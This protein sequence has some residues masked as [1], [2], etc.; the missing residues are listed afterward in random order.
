MG[1]RYAPVPSVTIVMVTVAILAAVATTLV[2]LP[3]ILVLGRLHP[4]WRRGERSQAV[5]SV[6]IGLHTAAA[7]WC[8]A[9]V[10]TTDLVP[11]AAW[12][13]T[14]VSVLLACA[15]TA[16]TRVPDVKRLRLVSVSS[17]LFL[18]ATV[19]CLIGL[20]PEQG[21]DR[22]VPKV[23]AEVPSWKRGNARPEAP[24]VVLITLDTFR[25]DRIGA[26]GQSPTLTPEIDRLA[27]EGVLFERAL[28]AAPWTVPSIASIL[29]GLPALEHRAGM[30]SSSGMTYDRSPLS[31]GHQTLA[32]D[33]AIA[34]YRTKAVVANAFLGKSMGVAQGFEEC[35]NLLSRAFVVGIL[36]KLPLTRLISNLE[37]V[38]RWGDYRAEGI[39]NQAL[40]WLAEES[41]EPLFLWAHYNDPHMPYQADPDVFLPGNLVDGSL[42]KVPE[43]GEDGLVV[44]EYFSS[45][46]PVRSGVL[47]LE[48]EDRQRLA[49]HYDRA[50][51]YV[52]KHLG[53][54]FEA[55]RERSKQRGRPLLIVLT[56]DHGEEL[57]DHGG[58][59]HGHDYY[60]EVTGV[61]LI[62]WSLNLVSPG[63]RVE[64]V[65]G[66]V[67]IAPTV[68]EWAN[69]PLPGRD[70]GDLPEDHG[71]SLLPCFRGDTEAPNRRRYSG[72]NLYGLPAGQ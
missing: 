67:D 55:L 36:E 52:D 27:T 70:S 11:T 65:V 18:I 68:R 5:W 32:E 4:A 38:R 37:G 25:V 19:L 20:Q 43:T 39:N 48:Q 26:Y 9:D 40:R 44:G 30:P 41:P 63:R 23:A 1:V 50:I 54:L 62:F 15:A 12:S 46:V 10:L 47:W 59:E 61:P 24:D 45:G 71:R 51:R 6:T 58:F 14:G 33:F 2:V 16:S 66:H 3:L 56:A 13:V 72:S 69:L 57:W 21:G 8:V 35:V 34:G 29:T 22:G 64:A 53:R 42:E 49:E 7:A 28:A 17:L 60:Q 31:P